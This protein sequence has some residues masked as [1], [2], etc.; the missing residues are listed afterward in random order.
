MTMPALGWEVI[1][2]SISESP[3]NSD[4]D[5]HPGHPVGQ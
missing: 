5:A 4:W 3:K 1:P 2:D